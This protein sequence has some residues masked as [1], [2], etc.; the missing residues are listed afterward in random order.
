MHLA[1]A[2]STRVAIKTGSFAAA[3]AAARLA[4]C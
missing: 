3:A 2:S 4:T 1:Q